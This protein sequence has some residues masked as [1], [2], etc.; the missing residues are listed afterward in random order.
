MSKSIRSVVVSQNK[1]G[2]SSVCYDGDVKNID[3]FMPGVEE[4]CSY[5]LWA[6]DTMPASLEEDNPEISKLQP[7]KNGTIFRIIDLPPVSS[8]LTREDV[9]FNFETLPPP[10]ERT[11]STF[12]MQWG[13]LMYGIILEGEVTFV[14][15]DEEVVLKQGDVLVDRGS[16]HAWINHTDSNCRVALVLLAAN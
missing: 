3:H 15:D 2:R 11:K 10:E 14:L 5:N 8:Y 6:T 13:D 12:M 7:S 16:H 4:A 9:A 1:K